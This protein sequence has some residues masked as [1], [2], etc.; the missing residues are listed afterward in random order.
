MS[1]RRKAREALLKLLYLA[2]SRG[3]TLD[4]AYDEMSLAGREIELSQDSEQ[5][6]E[7]LPFA[8]RLSE[9]QKDFVLTLGTRIERNRDRFESIISPLLKNWDYSRVA[10]IDRIILMIALAEMLFRPDIPFAVSIDEAIEL[11]KRYSSEKSP[12]FVN[13][14]LDAAS[15]T[16][17]S[18]QSP[19]VG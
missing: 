14:I 8:V 3:I 10:R 6:R 7:L 4:E 11:A 17:D 19:E 12:S 9:S 16:I 2:E 5:V 18:R 13:G 15:R 1:R